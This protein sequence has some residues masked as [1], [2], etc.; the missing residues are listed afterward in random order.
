M[1]FSNGKYVFR[2]GAKYNFNYEAAINVWFQNTTKFN[3]FCTEIMPQHGRPTEY[4]FCDQYQYLLIITCTS[5]VTG[6][7]LF[8]YK[9]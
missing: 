7:L 9:E 8:N 4:L 5:M 3:S 6:D 1:K 2:H